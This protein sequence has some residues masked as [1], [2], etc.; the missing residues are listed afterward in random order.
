MD[1]AL[2]QRS[3]D[4]AVTLGYRRLALTPINGDVFMDKKFVER[5]QYIENSS[6]EIIEF[7]TNFIGADEAAIASL[8]SLKKVSL[9]EISVYGHDADS[10]QSVT[11]RGTKQFDRLV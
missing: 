11:R 1:D 9:M 3:V 10:F 4:Q 2:F 5:L 8:L 7:Y 6:I